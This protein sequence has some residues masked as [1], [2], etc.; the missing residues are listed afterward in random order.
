MFH[1][2]LFAA[3]ARFGKSKTM[4]QIPHHRMRQDDESI[5]ELAGEALLKDIPQHITELTL[6]TLSLLPMI[7]IDRHLINRQSPSIVVSI[8]LYLLFPA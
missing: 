5:D 7:C 6:F 1:L 4:G 8:S 3:F 2:T